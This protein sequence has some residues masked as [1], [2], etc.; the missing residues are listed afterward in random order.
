MENLEE[1]TITEETLF[2]GRIIELKLAEVAL[3]NGKTAKRELIHHS[4]AVAIIPVTAD[5]RLILV[6]Q[7][8]KPLEKTIIEIP[9]GKIEPGEDHALTARRELEEETG[10][11]S[12]ELEYVTAFYTSP[13]F[14]DELLHIYLAKD[15]YHPKERRTLDE[16]EFINVLTVSLDEAKQLMENQLI[17]DAKT[18]YAIQYLEM[19]LLKA[20]LEDN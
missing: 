4:G 13:G 8:R 19:S 7:F 2:K 11:A 15:L 3:P 18:I 1:K 6:E 9:A 5:H 16:D 12:G 14:A 10:F 17:V 20:Q